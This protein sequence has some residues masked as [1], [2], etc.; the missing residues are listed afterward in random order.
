[1]I[2]RSG[3]SDQRLQHP[4]REVLLHEICQPVEH[5]V[6]RRHGGAEQGLQDRGVFEQAMQVQTQHVAGSVLPAQGLA[7]RAEWWACW[8][9]CPIVA[10]SGPLMFFLA[11]VWCCNVPVIATGCCK[12]SARI[13][14]V[15]IA[16]IEIW[17]AWY[18]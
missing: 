3:G 14:D 6:E 16:S 17:G 12:S 15:G 7:L 4:W 11:L 1:M 18:T 2:A 8:L 10:R 5:T 9:I 13:G